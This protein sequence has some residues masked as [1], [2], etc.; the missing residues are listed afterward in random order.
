MSELQEKY[1]EYLTVPTAK[2]KYIRE[3]YSVELR[4]GK[5]LEKVTQKRIGRCPAHFI[6]ANIL[7]IPEFLSEF[8]PPHTSIS[9]HTLY[10]ILRGLLVTQD[11]M[12][13]ILKLLQFL[14]L[15]METRGLKVVENIISYD[16][17][18]SIL[19]YCQTGYPMPVIDAAC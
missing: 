2:L 10:K 19:K 4:K 14:I 9:E 12:E 15:A 6:N 5:R 7:A 3:Q 1:R 18:K 13:I 17:L 16:M 11:D 8:I